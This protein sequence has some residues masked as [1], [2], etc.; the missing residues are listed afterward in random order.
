MVPIVGSMAI[1][2]VFKAGGLLTGLGST[3]GKLKETQMNSKSTTTEMKRMTGATHKLRSALAMIGV[4]GFAALLMTT[5]Q[6]AGSLSKIKHEMMML[7]WS[8]GRHLKPALDAVA[9]VL[10]GI[11]TGDWTTVKQGVMDLTK[12]VIILMGKAGDILI[13]VIWGEGTAAKVAAD[14]ERWMDGLVTAWNDRD[15]KGLA[16]SAAEAFRWV[17]SRVTGT[18]G[19]KED[20]KALELKQAGIRAKEKRDALQKELEAVDP[21]WTAK[22]AMESS[23]YGPSKQTGGI[24]PSTGLYN[25]HVGEMVTPAGASPMSGGGGTTNITLDFSGTNINLANGV[26]LDEFANTIS[27]KIAERQGSRIY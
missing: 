11:R 26:E 10:R 22:R 17:W 12:E 16:T 20:L 6:L 23:I 9:D 2:G 14:F 19:V 8:V 1:S 18:K 21:I 7:A 25:M 13:D 4:G 27:L 15:L 24:I 5:P 3:I